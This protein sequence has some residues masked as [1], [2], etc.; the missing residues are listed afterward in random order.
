MWVELNIIKEKPL[1]ASLIYK[2]NIGSTMILFLFYFCAINMKTRFL[3]NF[4][5][6]VTL[7]IPFMYHLYSNDYCKHLILTTIFAHYQDPMLN[8]FYLCLRPKNILLYHNS[9][10]CFRSRI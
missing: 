6:L 4:S 2:I 8:F 7:E 1:I 5:F 10:V 9:F 3:R